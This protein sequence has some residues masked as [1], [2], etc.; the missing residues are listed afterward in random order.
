MLGTALIG[1]KLASMWIGLANSI[2]AARVAMAAG[3]VGMA[4]VTAAANGSRVAILA[5]AAAT[6]SWSVLLSAAGGPMGLLIA[7]AT[8]ILGI[9]LTR[10]D[11]A[12]EAMTKHRDIVDKVKNA[13][14]RADK[15]SANWAKN[16]KGVT[17]SQATANL[18]TMR[19]NL[20]QMISDIDRTSA[21]FRTSL[22]R[23]LMSSSPIAEENRKNVA[24]VIKALDELK[25]RQITLDQF[26]ERVDAVNK[27]TKTKAIQ[28]WTLNLQEMA[29]KAK[30]AETGVR[31]AELVLKAITGTAEDASKAGKELA[32]SFDN[33]GNAVD[34]ATEKIKAY[35]KA[36]NDLKKTIP[37]LKV[38]AEKVED[39]EA[40]D[41]L[42]ATLL[43]DGPPTPETSSLIAKARAAIEE[44][45]TTQL[46]DAMPGLS[47]GYYNRL[48]QKESGGD[49]KARAKTSSATGIAQFT[50]GT[51]LGLFD[52]VFPALANYDQ[53]A[54][55]ALRTNDEMSRKMLERL[56]QEN[57]QSLASRG[58]AANDTTLYL[59]HFLGAGDAIK[60]LLANPNELAENIVK[61][62]SVNANKAV[63]KQGMT[64]GDLI[65]W[66]AKTMGSSGGRGGVSTIKTADLLSSGRTQ[67]ETDAAAEEKRKQE[68]LDALVKKR[69][70]ANRELDAEIA[71]LGMSATQQEIINELSKL[72]LDANSEEGRLLA[73]KIT[74]KN[75]E[76][77]LQQEITNLQA[78]QSSL[79][80][81]ITYATQQ[82]DASAAEAL[83]LQLVEVNNQLK[84]AVQNG[85]A[86]WQSMGGPNADAAIAKLRAV[87]TQTENLGRKFLMTGQQIDESLAGMGTDAL[88]SFAQDIADGED[89]LDSLGNAIR[90]MAADFLL[91]IG[92][93]IA[94]QAIFNAMQSM[95]F[96]KGVMG[97]VG[98]IFHEGGVAGQATQ[99]RAVNPSWFSGAVKYHTGG[100]AGLASNEVPA[101]LEKGETIRTEEQEAALQNRM[102]GGGGGTPNLKIVNAIDAGDFVSQGLGTE[103]GERAFLNFIRANSSAVKGALG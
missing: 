47:A 102:A 34:G 78:Q 25:S 13:Y 71:G 90:K 8:T 58:I 87:N 73:E 88:A 11:D 38:E 69:R 48:I 18:A 1:L 30:D 39:Y 96:G 40:L 95:G 35:E 94:Q 51:W 93:M 100:I 89:A 5:A 41:K 98:S 17:E 29:D 74:R 43:A 2:G 75:Q 79:Q 91:Q 4:Q 27:A 45:Y 14:E 44:K 55:L 21:A 15:S 33:T 83:K 64:T 20:D 59:A 72:Q 19:K 7:G 60:V 85:I 28:E 46:L 50:D 99:G 26:K 6:R 16:I 54:K 32:G 76:R 65:A 3:A 49:S 53:A 12:T 67:A 62:E 42:T 24:E 81:Q 70:E 57:Q 36:L 37:A 86:F 63:F 22:S 101:I 52:K 23:P 103:V 9:W 56:T 31:D 68:A 77:D 92:K 10:T 61:K 82:G 84:V 97:L 66:A 80:A